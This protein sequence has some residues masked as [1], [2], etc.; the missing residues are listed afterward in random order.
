MRIGFDARAVRY[1]G[2]IGIYS[3]N[4]LQQFADFGEEFVV[5]CEDQE[6][7]NIPKAGSFTLISANM[8]PVSLAGRG[9]FRS[10]VKE[11]GVDLLHVPSPWAPTP[12]PVP[13][14]STMHDVTPFLDP[15]SVPLTLRIRYKR[16][17]RQ[18]L[19]SQT[20]KTRSPLRS[21]GLLPD[22]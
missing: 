4:L 21:L 12:L 5:F 3:R 6:K 18:T 19:E 7:V 1:R 13:L 15:G 11:S 2:G 22:R 17:L 8:D 10:L 20:Q 16:Q 9:A 14:V